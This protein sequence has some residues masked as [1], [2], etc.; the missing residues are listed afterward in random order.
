MNLEAKKFRVELARPREKAAAGAVERSA[1]CRRGRRL[2]VIG[3]KIA[4]Y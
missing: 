1:A 2:D 3:A 4:S